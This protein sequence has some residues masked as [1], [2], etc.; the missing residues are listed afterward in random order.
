[1]NFNG[2]LIGRFTPP[3]PDHLPY[4][5]PIPSIHLSIYL[6]IHLSVIRFAPSGPDHLLPYFIP[7]PSIYLLIYLSTTCKPKNIII[8]TF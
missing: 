7:I 3:R 1:M 2:C 5:I 8:I 4:P 6:T